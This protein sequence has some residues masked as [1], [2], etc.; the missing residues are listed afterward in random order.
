MAERD[1]SSD[2]VLRVHTAMRGLAHRTLLYSHAAAAR[3]GLHPTDLT[4]LDLLRSHG[5]M[6]PG[7]LAAETGLTPGAI[8]AV[9]D[10]L[11]RK[12]HA[13]RARDRH[14]RRRVLVVAQDRTNET[15]SVFQAMIAAASRLCAGYS[16][17]DLR[18]IIRFAEQA[19]AML[20]Q[21]ALELGRQQP[22]ASKPPRRHAGQP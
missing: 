20:H 8:T 21:Q 18:L 11:E 9:V 4:C 3:L 1:D 15:A 5:P 6:P 13:K 12:G 19:S 14:D 2:L 7:Q 17:R 16:D 10:R 22:A